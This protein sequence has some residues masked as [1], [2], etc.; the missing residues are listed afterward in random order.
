MRE[1]D[2]NDILTMAAFENL[3][4]CEVR[5]CINS[6]TLYFLV[7][8]GKAALAIGKD[9]KKIKNAERTL[10]KSI[11][12]FEFSEDN[13][14]FIKNL[15][16]QA[17]RIDVNGERVTVSIMN[18]DRGAVIGRSGSNIKIIRELLERNIGVKDLKIL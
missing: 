12:V 15:I 13:K 9:G 16:P 14:Q 4:G 5:D 7:G 8:P 17:Q 18:K 3:T 11:K 2:T 1:F 6:D 10:R